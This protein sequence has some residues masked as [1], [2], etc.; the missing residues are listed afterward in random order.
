[1][2]MMIFKVK[3]TAYTDETTELVL[4]PKADEYDGDKPIFIEKNLVSTEEYK[5]FVKE[6]ETPV[7]NVQYIT[8]EVP[9]GAVQGGI[10]YDI[11]CN[12]E[13][14]GKLTVIDENQYIIDNMAVGNSKE[15][16]KGGFD[17]KQYI[18][19]LA[20]V[21]GAIALIVV[22]SV[23]GKSKPK[24]EIPVEETETPVSERESIPV[25]TEAVT[26]ETTTA[27]SES[28]AATASETFEVTSSNVTTEQQPE[29][30]ELD[31]ISVHFIDVG[32]GDSIYAELP[33]DTSLLIDAGE[34]G[35]QVIEYLYSLN[36][37]DID[38]VVATHPHADHI[39]GMAKVLSTFDIGELIIPE[40]PE[41]L[42]PVTEIY[43]EFTTSVAEKG[44]TVKNAQ[45][46]VKYSV[47]DVCNF[48]ILSPSEGI[49]YDE[50]N[51]YS[52][53]I[54]LSYGDTSY[55]FTGDIESVAE[56][57]VLKTDIDVSDTEVLKVSHHGSDTSSV[58]A[59][60]NTVSPKIAVISVGV[61]NEY[62]HPSDTVIE[63]LTSVGADIHR[64]DKEGTIIVKSDGADVWVEYPYIPEVTET[65]APASSY[66]G[67][68][69]SSKGS[70]KL[71]FNVNG[72][73]GEIETLTITEGFN[74]KLPTEGYTRD[75]YDF[76]GW[77]E[78]ADGRYPLYSYSMPD[79]DVILYAVWEAKEYTVTYDSNGG[80][81]LVVPYKVKVNEEV[82]L[83]TEGLE[84]G[85][86]VLVGW[87]T[88]P[89]A[90]SAVK[91]LFMP[92]KDITLYA[93]WAEEA[94][95][96]ITLM[97][98]G[99]ESSFTY[100]IGE[101]LNCRDDFGIVK[102]G[103]IVSGWTLYDGYGDIIQHMTVRGD[104]TLYA[105]WEEA[106]Y[107]DIT[108]DM[109]YLNK[110]NAIIKVP[111]NMNGI[112]TV[113]LPEV[114]NEKTHKSGYTYG[115]S[116]RQNGMLEYYGGT[117]AEFTKPTTVY[118]VRNIYYGGNGTK[119]YPYLINSWEHIKLMS[120]KGVQG[121]YEQISDIQ[122]PD[123]YLHTSIPVKIPNESV[124]NSSYSNFIY[125]GGGFVISNLHSKGGL[126]D[127]LV[128][129]RI[130]KLVI[131]N[132]AI[133]V[134]RESECIGAIANKVVTTTFG[135]D[136][137]TVASGNSI[138]E[139]CAVIG[140]NFEVR[141]DI[142]YV[143]SI[144]G[145][146]GYIRDTYSTNCYMYAREGAT[147]EYMGGIAG[148]AAEISGCAITGYSA[149]GC[150]KDGVYNIINLG[151][152]VA[153]GSGFPIE[154]KNHTFQYI[155]CSVSDTAVRDIVLNNAQNIGGIMCSAGGANSPYITRCYISNSVMNGNVT[156][157]IV[158]YDGESL[159]VH[160]VSFVI[161]DNT[162]KYPNI[163]QASESNET[164][165]VF[166]T[167]IIRV[168]FDG[169]KVDGVTY[170]LGDKWT[171]NSNINDGYAIPIELTIFLEQ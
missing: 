96:K 26:S 1:M 100:T 12:L 37:S 28:E 15:K 80:L 156:G 32:Q 127:E 93:V 52:V 149:E 116:S 99:Q 85:E 130:R 72:G 51:D 76:V 144:I 95:A 64:T 30:I 6:T 163:G 14:E 125:N 66:S 83:P 162:N 49:S 82:P 69:S 126:F 78:T 107:I 57:N 145:Y 43:T 23:I 48:E 13:S 10:T 117:I 40:V 41:E 90:R 34:T 56:Y 8:Y 150:V 155:G 101:E 68:S 59:F 123:S 103:Y 91:T 29:V 102:D 119:E 92:N 158:G 9:D 7:V 63:R 147:I 97:A 140:S 84:N 137:N 75:G 94:Q 17:I 55:L 105:V 11:I 70:Y 161:V 134:D 4:V 164:A 157:S 110:P 87:N 170:I 27:F 44:I 124:D 148:G 50:L 122:M 88:K 114:D 58:E 138:I 16:K 165:T 5:D 20:I 146:G 31:D 53:V 22:F 166:G 18:P 153:D 133:T 131:S 151:G 47:S 128:S 25:L 168:P 169:L 171:R 45:K 89:N 121:Y 3:L 167:Q 136:A 106:T 98:D 139:K 109:S 38:Y 73:E 112:A 42:I 77:S 135:K 33:N 86:L 2:G 120:E 36:V 21:G 19:L 79:R 129:S 71:S 104:T 46:G 74:V 108:I 159:M 61:E 154:R 118:R 65:T 141:S 24:T 60:I 62:G 39:G 143:G 160:T 111:L 152:V 142:K 67:G 54:K 35:E 81:G 132:A 115:W 113:L